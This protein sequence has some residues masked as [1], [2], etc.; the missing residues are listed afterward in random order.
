[1]DGR[2][3]I[4]FSGEGGKIG[5]KSQGGRDETRRTAAGMEGDE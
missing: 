3:C 2:V 5:G 4:K 1:M